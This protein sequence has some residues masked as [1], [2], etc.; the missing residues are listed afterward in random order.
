[1]SIKE[2]EEVLAQVEEVF[3]KKKQLYAAYGIDE[4]ELTDTSGLS[5]LEKKALKEDAAEFLK[6]LEIAKRDARAKAEYEKFPSKGRIGK[7]RKNFI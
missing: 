1:M 7:R 4:K 2:I 3:R 6:E 5:E